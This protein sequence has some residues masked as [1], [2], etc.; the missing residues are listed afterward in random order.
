M[1]CGSRG[2]VLL[3]RWQISVHLPRPT[4]PQDVP[5]GRRVDRNCWSDHASRVGESLECLL[6]A[7]KQDAIAARSTMKDDG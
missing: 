3:V 1:S 2:W 6:A 5:A 4:Y 7:L